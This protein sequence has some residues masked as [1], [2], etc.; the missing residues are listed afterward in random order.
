MPFYTLKDLRHFSFSIANKKN[1]LSRH[2]NRYSIVT[3][4]Y[5]AQHHMRR[6]FAKCSLACIR[7]LTKVCS[8]I[9]MAIKLKKPVSS[10]QN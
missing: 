10:V 3:P 9:T 1:V 2:N 7:A 5:K 8:K 6:D 4:K